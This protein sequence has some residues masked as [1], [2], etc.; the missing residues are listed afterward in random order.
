[1]GATLSSEQL[2]DIEK[3]THF[4]RKE[5]TRMQKRFMAMDADK[6]GFITVQQF[7]LL[8]EL[9]CNPLCERI[10]ASFDANK[11]HALH[12][13][14]PAVRVHAYDSTRKDNK[15]DF[16]EFLTHLDVFH[17]TT[18]SSDKLQV[19]ARAV[20][21]RPAWLPTL[22]PRCSFAFACST[23]KATAASAWTRRG[24]HR[25][26]PPPFPHPSPRLTGCVAVGHLRSRW[27]GLVPDAYS[28]GAAAS[29]TCVSL[30]SCDV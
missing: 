4:N 23:L 28:T 15:I 9:C 22:T 5:I 10:V 21:A 6:K 14:A 26:L 30:R 27:H 24:I 12:C 2:D 11:V 25:P 8:P 18:E 13:T 1:M 29:H 3:R 7:A 19:A 17:P 16:T 20:V